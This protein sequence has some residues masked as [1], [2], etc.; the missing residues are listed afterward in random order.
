MTRAGEW[1]WGTLE[2]QDWGCSKAPFLI[3]CVTCGQSLHLSE[4]PF[5]YPNL[6]AAS[7]ALTFPSLVSVEVHLPLQ[8]RAFLWVSHAVCFGVAGLSCW[9]SDPVMDGA[10]HPGTREQDEVTGERD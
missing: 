9:F 4:L 1:Q 7:S 6:Q 2:S 10:V 5:L 8:S 3:R